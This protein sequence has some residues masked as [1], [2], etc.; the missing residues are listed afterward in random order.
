ME[1]MN[2]ADTAYISST[3]S[4]L[5]NLI[6]KAYPSTEDW[7]EL[8]N[9]AKR[10]M[11]EITNLGYERNCDRAKSSRL[12]I[13]YQSQFIPLFPSVQRQVNYYVESLL[14]NTP[15][16]NT[17]HGCSA[18]DVSTATRHALKFLRLCLVPKWNIL[19]VPIH[20]D[21]P[22][23]L[24]AA[25]IAA[26]QCDTHISL[27]RLLSCESAD[28]RCCNEASQALSNLVTTNAITSRILLE[29]TSENHSWSDMVSFAATTTASKSLSSA[30]SNRNILAQTVAALFNGL[31]ALQKSTSVDANVL[32]QNLIRDTNLFYN[33]VINIVPPT[34]LPDK[35]NPFD[36][37]FK[38]KQEE[39]K[40]NDTAYSWEVDSATEWI[41][42]LLMGKL[43]IE[44]D[45][46]STIYE[47]LSPVHC[48]GSQTKTKDAQVTFL[49]FLTSFLLD[50]NDEIHSYF[51]YKAWWQSSLRCIDSQTVNL[52]RS[53][54]SLRYGTEYESDTTAC[55]YM[56][57]IL[58]AV[59]VFI[60][61]STNNENNTDS[62]MIMMKTFLGQETTLLQ[63]VCIDLATI[64]DKVSIANR[65]KRTREMVM[66]DY[67]QNLVK[68]Y[69][70]IV[71]NV[72]F[73]CKAVQ[74]MLRHPLIRSE[75][76]TRLHV[77]MSCTSLSYACVGLREWAIVALRNL[78]EGNVENQRA[79]ESLS[80]QEAVN[81][82]ELTRLGFGID[83]DAKGDVRVVPPK[84][85]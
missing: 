75:P 40:G 27:I 85:N 16:N 47:S 13:F 28:S 23:P 44:H 77:I 46:F 17:E 78:L 73:R 34:S 79:L 50:S 25:Q 14:A 22:T 83:L 15:N 7:R 36:H 67:D 10:L 24:F 84:T 37:D 61:N 1:E 9:V 60:P 71:A 20:T 68:L 55:I 32:V 26:A 43:V 35:W 80:P 33:L 38:L 6:Q 21:D 76:R 62:A 30:R 29:Y 69:L 66:S 8:W 82:D 65:G 72:S 5:Q 52:G 42:R 3:N 53:T 4:M 64:V 54:L 49:H 39:S 63:D 45:L 56:L 57:Q 12:I 41:L 11:N 48:N 81:S 2:P 19:V 74:D 59:M 31:T 58:A 51:R 70:Q 18:L